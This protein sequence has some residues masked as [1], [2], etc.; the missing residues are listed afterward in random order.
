[1]VPRFGY[2]SWKPQ[3]PY[4]LPVSLTVPYRMYLCAF[5]VVV[6]F[7]PQF[8]IFLHLGRVNSHEKE[9]FRATI[10]NTWWQQGGGDL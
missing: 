5:L 2:I 1:M 4:F 6:I 7:E 8:V 10:E 9:R 3:G